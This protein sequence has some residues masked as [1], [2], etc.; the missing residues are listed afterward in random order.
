MKDDL[1]VQCSAEERMR[2][3]DQRSMCSILCARVQKRF[4]PARRTFKKKR[5]DGL[6]CRDHTSRL[7][8]TEIEPPVVRVQ[9]DP[10]DLKPD[11]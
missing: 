2:M 9:A 3:A 11:A 6:L 8:K 10:F 5:A 1:V 7:H 4:K